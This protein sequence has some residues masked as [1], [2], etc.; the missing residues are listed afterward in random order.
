MSTNK[1][2][3]QV[4]SIF[5]SITLS[6]SIAKIAQNFSWFALIAFLLTLFLS[7]N[8]FYAKF[9]QLN[10]D[11]SNES[12]GGFNFTINIL[13]LACFAFMPFFQNNFLCLMG[14]QIALR[15]FDSTLIFSNNSW[16]LKNIEILEK[17]WLIFDF[18]YFLIIISFLIIYV[19]FKSIG[20]YL[21]SLY[22]LLCI[23]ESLFD[24]FINR[25]LYGISKKEN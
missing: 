20:I 25:N 4:T 13:T 24:F 2:I 21:L 11:N 19:F 5:L 16:K 14:T 9:H 18:S 8:F 1:F 22:L 17:R 6:N 3:I 23:F 15:I 12:K 10:S 7:I